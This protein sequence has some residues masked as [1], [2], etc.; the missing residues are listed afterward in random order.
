MDTDSSYM[1]LPS[2]KRV[3][4]DFVAIQTC[5]YSKPADPESSEVAKVGRFTKDFVKYNQGEE[6]ELN[7]SDKER[8]VCALYQV[9]RSWTDFTFHLPTKEEINDHWDISF[10]K[11]LK[12]LVRAVNFGGVGNPCFCVGCVMRCLKRKKMKWLPPKELNTGHS[13]KLI[14]S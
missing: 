3:S 14:R 9:S 10:P 6:L 2:V 8:R 13:F 1:W 12:P 11:L 7:W 4:E 5:K